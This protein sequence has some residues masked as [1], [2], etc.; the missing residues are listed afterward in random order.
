MPASSES[1]NTSAY[2]GSFQNIIKS[3]GV[4]SASYDNPPRNQQDILDRL[5]MPRA[6]LSP[7]RF[8]D[9]DVREFQKQLRHIRA[10]ESGI[11]AVA[12]PVLTGG[13]QYNGLYDL[14]FTNMSPPIPVDNTTIPKPDFYL[15]APAD[16][17]P[18]KIRDDLRQRIEPS[19]NRECPLLPNFFIEYKPPSGNSDVAERQAIWDGCHGARAMQE[20]Q[21]YGSSES[22]IDETARTFS[23]TVNTDHV[24]I[25]SHHMSA[26]QNPSQ[27]LYYTTPIDASSLAGQPSRVRQTL[28]MTR[29]CADL[30]GELRDSTILATNLR[31]QYYDNGLEIANFESAPYSP[32]SLQSRPPL[33]ESASFPTPTLSE[34]NVG[35]INEAEDQQCLAQTALELPTC[36]RKRASKRSHTHRSNISNGEVNKSSTGPPRRTNGSEPMDNFGGRRR[37][38]RLRERASSLI[39]SDVLKS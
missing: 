5:E 18:Q 27:P 15:G 7:S 30:A 21:S 12:T 24:Q 10:T 28:C 13:F 16:T 11:Q 31:T 1:K 8:T 29:N 22:I 9:H 3:K 25:Y 33:A 36:A 34:S 14:P 4:Q 6:S 17:I 38:I 23:I 39:A 19:S 32:S 2:S 35:G 37:S 26:S 20:Y